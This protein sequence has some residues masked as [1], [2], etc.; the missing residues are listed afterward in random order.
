[1]NQIKFLKITDLSH[2]LES[3]DFYSSLIS[4]HLKVN[5]SHIEKPHK[6][7]FYAVFLFTRGK[8]VH[9]IDF[10]VYDIKP[11]AVFFLSPGQTHSWTLSEDIEGFLFFHSKEFYDLGFVSNSI[12]DFP[13]FES[14]HTS[15]CFNLND[16][17]L[18]R[19]RIIFEDILVE[20]QTLHW[21]RKQLILSYLTQIYIKINRFIEEQNEGQ[22]NQLRHYQ[23]IFNQ[24]ESL[25]EKNYVTNKLASIYANELNISQ[26]HLNRVVKSITTKTT[27]DIILDRIILEAKRILIY[28]DKSFAEIAADL[29]YDDYAYFSK[30]FKKRVGVSPSEFIKKYRVK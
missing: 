2:H 19:L 4:N 3:E 15:K 12:K 27:T 6:H 23:F 30:I 14:N 16:K 21:K 24:F 22:F 28:T 13:F 11:G 20:Y 29:G 25:L 7:D 1:M 26:K 17:N 18:E 8:G 5:H 10:Q 9:E